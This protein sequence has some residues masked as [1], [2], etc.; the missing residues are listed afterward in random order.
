[1]RNTARLRPRHLALALP[2]LASAA[3]AAPARAEVA[4]G[5]N[6]EVNHSIEFGVLE[7]WNAG[8]TVRV[9][10]RRGA[11]LIATKTVV[12]DASR[13]VDI[14]H[15]GGSD[16]WEGVPGRTPDIKPGDRVVAT[17]LDPATGNPT[18]DVDYL[19]VRNIVFD[20]NA[21]GTMTGFARGR[22]T[23]PGV[24]NINAPIDAAADVI[25]ARRVA[26]DRFDRVFAPADLDATGAFNNVFIGGVPLSGELFIDHIEQSG[27][28]NG[29]TTAS[30]SSD[31]VER[32]CGALATTALSS[33]SHAVINAANVGTDLVIGGP[34][35]APTTVT[36]I[37]FG[38]R[39]YV[40]DNSA[41]DTWSARIPAADLA[42]LAN[43]ASHTLT[44]T[45]SDSAPA[46]S[47]TIRKDVTP[48]SVG[49]TLSPG[50]YTGAQS[51]A[52]RSDGGEDVRYTLDGSLPTASS[53]VYDGT[54]LVL[55][56]GTH[57]IRAFATDAAGNRH[58]VTLNY[59]ILAPVVAGPAGGTAGGA[60]TTVATPAG[61]GSTP[62]GTS[63]AGGITAAA[64]RVALR[65]FAT[66]PRVKRS[67]ASRYGI[68]V[69]M[70]VGGDAKVVRVRVYRRLRG[71]RRV[72]VATAFR[73]PRGAGVNRLSLREPR[74]RRDLRIGDYEVEATPGASRTD[75][76]ASSRARFR[77]V[78]G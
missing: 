4:P 26:G 28:G 77:V 41:P 63:A 59:T 72:L 20:E 53:R 58:D 45:F 56:V 68:R 15:L 43:N 6:L 70:R 29:T 32:P 34:R 64:G 42:A 75:L 39:T 27:G 2:L 66:P 51:V 76:G 18:A 36:G 73:A 22:E 65:A 38:G 60:G 16:C 10:V 71:G 54:P 40:A 12:F 44:V 57:T 67:R 49:A 13:T 61:T 69:V 8:Q 11:T 7:G 62:A 3:L 33:A 55:G 50:T 19:F 78:A 31:E 30:R 9:D 46:E 17:V 21:D 35:L 37:T 1:M 25:E 14:N 23:S 52:L 47:R 24:F 74:L 48:P 5:R